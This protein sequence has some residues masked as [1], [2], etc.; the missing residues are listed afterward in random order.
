MRWT[1]V[2][3]FAL[4]VAF[5]A[6]MATA[7]R[8]SSRAVW[9]YAALPGL[10]LGAI[11]TT[12]VV[13]VQ[14][15]T[16]PD[17]ISTA[18]GLFITSRGLGGTVG[19]AVY[20]AVFNGAMGRVGEKVA[21]VVVPLGVEPGDVPAFVQGLVSRNGTALSEIKGVTGQVVEEGGRALLNTFVEAFRR[22]WISAGC[23]VAVATVGKLDFFCESISLL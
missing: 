9:G 18:S 16:P 23:F 3:S 1:T 11:A 20:T 13:V 4:L 15:S 17:L 22:V 7:T 5:F 19:L 10:A 8:G 14:L 6:A 21:S 2:L 12:L